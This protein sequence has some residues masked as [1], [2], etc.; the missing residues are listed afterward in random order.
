MISDRLEYI[1]GHGRS[2]LTQ[3]YINVLVRVLHTL[4]DER[5]TYLMKAFFLPRDSAS[6][7]G[8]SGYVSRYRRSGTVQTQRRDESCDAT[9]PSGCRY[10]A[11][12]DDPVLE[13]YQINVDCSDAD[14]LQALFPRSILYNLDLSSTPAL[15]SS[16]IVA[17]NPGTGPTIDEHWLRTRIPW[18]TRIRRSQRRVVSGRNLADDR[19]GLGEDSGKRIEE[20]RGRQVVAS[21]RGKGL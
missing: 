21:S 3:G 2:S 15:L 10:T 9:I 4:K 16:A 20:R 11:Y 18:Q 7:H 17:H 8:H 14:S 5:V 13:D 12:G 1:Q 19:R 6:D